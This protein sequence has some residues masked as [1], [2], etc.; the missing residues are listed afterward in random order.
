MVF[1][2]FVDLIEMYKDYTVKLIIILA[3][4]VCD[5]ISGL[6]KAFANEGYNS[7]KMRTGMIHKMSELFCFL[8]CVLCDFTLP[9]LN[10][11]LPFSIATGITCYLVF[12]EV[13]SIIEN[14]GLLNP[15]IGKYLTGIFEKL[16]KDD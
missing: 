14:I 15:D 3:F 13:G 11:M 6:L 5:I 10:I 7:S 12:M 2:D 9:R 8:F 1:A 16:K 4:I